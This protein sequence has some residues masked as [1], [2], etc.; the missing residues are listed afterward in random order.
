MKVGL[1][2]RVST[3]RQA[4]EGD[5]LDAQRQRL[6]AYCQQQEGWLVV[7]I[8]ADEG[9]SA[10]DLDHRPDMLRLL[11]DCKA[12]KVE[13]VMF[14][15]LTRA[16]RSVLDTLEL[17]R[18]FGAHGIQA[19]ALNFDIDMTTATGRYML[20]SQAVNAQYERERTAERVREVM[21][22]RAKTG[23]RMGAPAPFGYDLKKRA[24][25][26]NPEEAQT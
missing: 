10:K 12:G 18:F 25:V 15:D 14:S 11:N 6:L 9:I 1:Y 16:S 2:I 8:Y 21:T 22:Y 3:S 7:D 17:T 26:V 24:L 4:K 5:S 23:R 20:N 13:L 19:K